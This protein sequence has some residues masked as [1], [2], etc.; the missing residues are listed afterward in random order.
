MAVVS[1]LEA[2]VVDLDSHRRLLG[3]PE[4]MIGADNLWRD[5]TANPYSADNTYLNRDFAIELRPYHIVRLP[6]GMPTF[7]YRAWGKPRIQVFLLE[8]ELDKIALLT[9]TIDSPIAVRGTCDGFRDNIVRMNRCTLIDPA[10]IV[11]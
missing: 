11:R 10:N 5:Y 1:V 8:S 4:V 2:Q 7:V 3:E 6:N 9:R